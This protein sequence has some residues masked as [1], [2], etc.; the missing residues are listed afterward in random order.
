VKVRHV[1]TAALVFFGL[2]LAGRWNFLLFHGIAE[3]FS[4]SVAGTVFMV[5]WYTRRQLKDAYFAFLG[6]GLLFV[7]W[8]D[9][10]HLLA[11]KG[12]GVFPGNG[13]NLPTQLWIADRYL[14][15]ISCLAAPWFAGRR[16]NHGIAFAAY[17]AATAC[18]LASIFVWKIFP[19]CF[20]EGVGLTPFKIASEYVISGIF[21]ASI[22]FLLRKKDHFD[23]QV[24]HLLVSAAGI[25]VASEMAFTLYT[26]V[27][28]LTNLIGH[29]LV[30]LSF[31]LVYQAVIGTDLV[32]K[33]ELNR[34]LQ[35]EIEDRIRTG[36]SL[37]RAKEEWERTFDA[38]P[39]MIAILD[40]RHR[41]LRVNEAMA[42]R[43]GKTPGE[44]VGLPCH[45]AVHGLPHPPGFCPHV[46]S[47][48]DGLRHTEEVHEDRLE[49]DFLVST[50]P[51]FGPQGERIASVH[52]ARDITES[53][54][55]AEELR[56]AKEG[57]EFRVAERTAELQDLAEKLREEL[58]NRRESERELKE[59]EERFRALV[60]HSPVGIFIVQGGRIV[61]RNPEQRRLFGPIP[62]DFPFETFRDVHPEDVAKFEDLCAAVAAGSRRARELELRFYPYGKA[63]DGVDMRWVHV[64]AGPMEYRGKEAALV[65][66]ADITRLKEMEY[67]FLVREKMASLGHVAAGIAHE[68]RNP[69]SGIN[70]HLSALEKA[71][72]DDEGMAEESR[73]QSGRIIGQI[74]S[75]SG[76][77]EAVIKKVMDFSRPGAPRMEMADLNLAIEEAI[78]FSA[79][80][81]RRSG[82][83]LDRANLTSLPKCPANSS[84]ITQVIMNL[85][86][87]AA[88]AMERQAAPKRLSV[89]T[90]V[91]KGCAVISVSDSGPG[92]P[93]AIRTKI[94]DPFFTTRRDGF[95]IGLSLCHR[96]ITDHRGTI[97]VETSRWGGTEFRIDLPIEA[98]IPVDVN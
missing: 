34:R 41:I 94:F 82:V 44:C 85:I 62:E 69:L 72:E 76:R 20:I 38:V 27:Y 19:D 51:L 47:L 59:S 78:D 96:I 39:E 32:R 87:N 4:V 88:Q 7:A 92:I 61:F 81:L 15:A 95:G 52:V 64:I 77:I 73:E 66:M 10:L 25:A 14:F 48:K 18:L 28:G 84:L 29:F 40:D 49:G 50:T 83:T 45:E 80:F 30:I 70:I 36:E 93:P 17:A 60:E 79:T 26:D 2:Y 58:R 86:T 8:L 1:I 57:L 91:E 22:V 13:A 55:A 9:L 3:M 23:S 97:R 65:I 11:Y 53:K 98:E 89:E 16:L 12:M 5:S 33:Y 43:L 63:R 75:A 46:Q 90:R 67:Q 42:Q 71:L 6:I 35:Q 31:Y 54:R 74:K 37:A 68:I 24:L 56:A 21:L